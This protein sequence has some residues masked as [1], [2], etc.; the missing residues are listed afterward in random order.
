M[1]TAITAAGKRF[2]FVHSQ[3]EVS[4]SAYEHL[5]QLYGQNP[6]SDADIVVVLGGDGFLLQVLG[7][8]RTSGKSVYGMNRGSV[9]FLLNSYQV[10]DLPERLDAAIAVSI[11]RLKIKITTLQGETIKATAVNDLSLFRMT[12]QS[13]HISISINDVVRMQELVCDGIIV[14]TPAGS[15]GYSLSAHGPILPLR[16]NLLALTPVSAFRPRRW[17]GALLDK[18]SKV[19]LEVLNP[20]KR[21]ALEERIL[22]QQ[23]IVHS[24]AI[25]RAYS[26]MNV[27]LYSC[28]VLI[29]V[30]SF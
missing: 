11:R 9:G 27:C 8:S 19:I 25:N 5:V 26:K 1:P 2:C 14:A 22:R 20:E 16:S 21:Q 18:S 3:T 15:T 4:L 17:P 12:G 24:G 29:S 30:T 13:A 6:V 7:E 23:F 28:S 10:T